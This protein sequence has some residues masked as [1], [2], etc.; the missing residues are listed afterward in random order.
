MS[1]VKN[2]VCREGDCKPLVFCLDFTQ[3]RAATTER[4]ETRQN[5]DRKNKGRRKGPDVIKLKAC[6]DYRPLVH[7]EGLA[8][9]QGE[10]DSSAEMGPG[11][12][13][14]KAGARMKRG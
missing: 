4:G 6:A 13:R 7:G 9:H 11:E 2:A 8:R 10:C 14:A 5:Y 3:Q 12:M 1:S